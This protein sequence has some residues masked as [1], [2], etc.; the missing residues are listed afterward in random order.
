MAPSSAAVLSRLTLPV[1][2]KTVLLAAVVVAAVAVLVVNTAAAAVVAAA[3]AVA[4]VIDRSRRFL[5]FTRGLVQTKSRFFM[6]VLRARPPGG[7]PPPAW[8][9]FPSIRRL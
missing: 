1:P 4:A 3:A 2:A 5:N 9:L 7:P 8:A 6:G